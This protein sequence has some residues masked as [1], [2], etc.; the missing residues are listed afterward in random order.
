MNVLV[1]GATGHF[2]SLLV[3]HLLKKLQPSQMAV[4]VR[5]VE[6]AN[7][8][9]QKG[10]E[11]RYGDFDYPDTLVN[12]FSNIDRLFIVS[13]DLDTE[14]RIRQHKAAVDAA[15][16]AGVKHI[17]Y[18]SIANANENTI[19]LAEVHRQTEAA[20]IET[21]I[22]FTFLRNNWYLENELSTFQA[23]ASGAP[24][25]TSAK[26][27]KVG[28][29]LKREYAEAAASALAGEGHENKVYEL[30]SEP[31]TQEEL[32]MALSK[33]IGKDISLMHVSDDVYIGGLKDAG[34]PDYVVNLLSDI[35]KGIREDSLNVVSFDLENLLGRPPLSL[36]E[37][38]AEAYKSL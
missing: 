6:K 22:P 13:T 27:G 11:V 9:A 31:K 35:Q 15:K 1:T 38:V 19:S 4:S 2:G 25:V 8:L 20:I 23:V 21:G 14:T 36:D 34:L 17:F 3:E 26:N 37:A 28:W 18:T 16:K 10:V 32:V 29:T 24:W 30:S 7:Y 12:A 33:V 5:N